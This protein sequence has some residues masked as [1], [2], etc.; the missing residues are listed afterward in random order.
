M[1]DHNVYRVGY[2]INNNKGKNFHYFIAKDAV[3][4][5]RV[6]DEMCEIKKVVNLRIFS[7]ARWDRFKDEWIDESAKV[8]LEISKHNKKFKVSDETAWAEQ[9]KKT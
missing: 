1:N 7:I 5:V 6:E 2:Q 3:D 4:A 8:S 9:R